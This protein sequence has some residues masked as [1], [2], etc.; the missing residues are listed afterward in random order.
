[1][2]PKWDGVE[3]RRYVPRKY[4]SDGGVQERRIHVRLTDEQCADI[5]QQI[6]SSIYE[7][8]GRSVVKKILWTL[9]AV[10]VAL[11]AWAAAKGY[12]KL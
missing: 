3:R 2:S 10:F 9:G 12:L 8:I 6:L 11:T 5:K 1:M 7:E 4:A